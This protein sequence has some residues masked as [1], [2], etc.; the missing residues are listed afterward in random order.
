MKIRLVILMLLSLCAVFSS[1][2]LGE[3]IYVHPQN[4]SDSSKG[5]FSAPFRTLKK[6]VS[7]VMPGDTIHLYPMVYQ[8]SLEFRNN[9][10]GTPDKPIVVEGH[11]A[12]IDGAVPLVLSSWEK[13]P[14]GIYKNTKLPLIKGFDISRYNFFF[15]NEMIRMGRTSKGIKAPFKPYESLKQGEW[16]YSESESAFYIK[17][18][19]GTSLTSYKITAPILSNGVSFT[20][21]SY[22]TIKN[23]TA[24]RVINDGFNIHGDCVGLYFENITARDCGDDGFSA[25]ENSLVRVNGFTS[26]GNSTGVCS[27]NNSSSEMA[28]ILIKDC[29][30]H[31]IFFPQGGVN[32]IRNCVVLS[33]SQKGITVGAQPDLNFYSTLI[34][35][36]L[37]VIRNGDPISIRVSVGGTLKINAALLSGIGLINEGTASLTNAVIGGDKGVS[38]EIRKDATWKANQNQYGLSAISL[39]GKVFTKED[40][41]EYKSITRQDS[42]SSWDLTTIDIK[43]QYGKAGVNIDLLPKF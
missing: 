38:L 21:C 42:Q 26:I 30:G 15:N 27:I 35:D 2:C 13:L 36:N 40:F 43:S 8:E 11:G 22:V 39:F 1:T 24:M 6:A 28:N 19:P 14:D 31:D 16:T 32:V 4:G 9:K 33:S 29:I 41:S 34:F 10:S 23:I 17:T 20:S 3:S 37:L 5:D 12:I 7:V 25:H 18:A